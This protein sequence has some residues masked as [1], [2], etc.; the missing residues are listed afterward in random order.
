MKILHVVPAIDPA[1]GGPAKS[2]PALCRALALAGQEVTIFTTAWPRCGPFEP[3]AP[4]AE[5]DGAVRLRVFPAAPFWLDAKVPSSPQLLE[6][7]RTMA[8]GFDVVHFHVIWNPVVTFGMQVMRR[9][10]RPYLVAP[11]GAMDPVV[12]SRHHWK[13]L[14]WT[15]LWERANVQGAACV[16]FTARAEAEKAGQCGWRFR[17][18]VIAPNLIDVDEW[19]NLPDRALFEKRFPA[20]RGREVVLFA[21]RINWVKN[22]D[23]LIRALVILRQKRPAACLVCAG[24]DNEGY[25]RE[26]EALT[27]RLVAA[28]HV[29]FAGMLQGEDLRAAYARADIFALVSKRENFGMAAG[30]ALACG[31]PLVIS[32]G[33]DLD[34]PAS[35]LVARTRQEPQAIA[36]ALARQLAL[37]GQATGIA[38]HARDLIAGSAAGAVA[39]LLHAYHAAV[40]GSSRML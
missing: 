38:A 10:Q 24:P 27:R 30:E 28:E 3:P 25:R 31:L 19:R 22:I 12:F 2:V 34:L 13:K 17:N 7:L 35:D 8:P 20:L 9:M 5:S 39:P 32:D 37:R 29:I 15:L 21:G 11:R 33:V 1:W 23:L 36:D 4:R 40:P 26:L 6:A 16:H 18:I 14:P